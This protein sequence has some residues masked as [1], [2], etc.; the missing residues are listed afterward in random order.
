MEGD[1]ILEERKK[2]AI[3]FLKTNYNWISYA[4]LAI[5][6]FISVKIR[7]KNI[8]G[9][10][11]ISTGG[12]A[13]GP[14]LD[15][16][17]FLRW[18]KY[19]VQHGT[20][21]ANDSMRY[22]PLGFDIKSELLLHPYMI[23]W[24]HNV[25][26]MFG[27]ES[28]TQSAALYP[29]F[30]FAITVIAFF[31]MTRK[32]FEGSLGNLKANIIALI[33][34]FFLTVIPALLP[35]TIAGIPEK[36]SAAFFFMFAAF[37]FFI[38]AWKS[39]TYKSQIPLAIVSGILTAMMALVWG[40]YIFVFVTIS[41]AVFIAF[42]IGL[43]D[44][45]KFAIYSSWLFSA[46]F[47]MMLF[48]NRYTIIGLLGPPTTAVAF[49]TFFVI[50]VHLLIYNTGLKKYT[51]HEKLSKIPKPV[52]SLIVAI[53]LGIILASLIFGPGFVF[54]KSIQVKNTLVTPVSDRL[55]VTVAENRQPF[56]TEW[57]ASFGPFIKGI[58]IF[59]WL[60]FVG[61]IYLFSFMIRKIGKKERFM[62][63]LSYTFF[64]LAIVFSRYSSN[65]LFNGTNLISLLTYALGFVV[66]IGTV[67]YYY[68]QYYKSNE[69][70]RL[71]RID[72]GI[73]LLFSLFFFS[74]IAARGAVRLIM[75]LVPSTSIIVSYFAVV[76]VDSVNKT[77]DNTKK[78]IAIVIATIVILS[79][80]FSAYSFYAASS[81]TASAYV[82]S[83]YNQQWQLAMSWVRENTSENAVFAHWWDYGYWIQ[84]IGER[85]TVLDGGNAISYWNHL[86]GRHALTGT[87]DA[88]SLEFLYSHNV[89][90]FLIDS[91]DIGKYSAFS[92]I[93][94]DEN[95]DRLSWIQT[96]HKDSSQT[97]EKKDSLVLFYSGGI[98][99]DEDIIYEQNGTRIFLPGGKAGIAGV[100]IE[101]DETGE[102][103]SNPIGIFVNNNQQYRIPLRY[104]YDSGEL[105]D[106]E[107][108]L[109][110]GGFIYPRV[111]SSGSKVEKDGSML[112]LSER[113]V[114]TQ[115]ARLYLYNEDNSYFKLAHSEDDV[116]VKQTKAQGIDSDFVYYGGLR[117]PIRIWEVDYPAGM[118]VNP[119]YVQKQFVNPELAVSTR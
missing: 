119:E 28:V 89:T 59:F 16:Y 56:F 84:T 101:R 115:L 78:L 94:S 7:T 65:S 90:H 104:M 38:F 11:D 70:H 33:S 35:R 18:A 118:E 27:S 97:I 17:L 52:I 107:S 88:A 111:D 95:Y 9:L 43:V 21:F 4:I 114:N 93:G 48:S 20:L 64:L 98:V 46:S 14:D 8:P 102:I 86:M 74:I 68:Y 105:L 116:V 23:A 112:Y 40:G 3:S 54:E 62:V 51:K 106:F 113:T 92:S 87:S 2:K 79:T 83:S 81:N 85:A 49:F 31:F 25:A 109:E 26:S 61:S 57:R 71:K 15:P 58:P 53:V 110:A 55:G 1:K 82:P 67:G 12:W 80:I 24:F 34:S 29:V 30:F 44:I 41:L 37:Y 66:L 99:L 5:I 75:V 73:L 63:T 76:S 108:G 72:F 50:L 47:I 36:E 91:T 19:I 22:V 10:R 45:K 6:V 117:G 13:L 100:L 42:I 60:F 39:K 103:I 32:M 96:F 77:K 69:L